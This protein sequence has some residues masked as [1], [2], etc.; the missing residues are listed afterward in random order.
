MPDHVQPNPPHRGEDRL[1]EANEQL[2]LTALRSLDEAEAAAQRWVTERTLNETLVRQQQL[3]RRVASQLTVT[4][5]H[6][7]KRLSQTD[8]REA[9]RKRRALPCAFRG[10]SRDGLGLPARW[11]C[12]APQSTMD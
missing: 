7:R 11:L 12:P 10:G 4:E 9:M 5:Q 6:E 1:R 3:L 2:M 8:R